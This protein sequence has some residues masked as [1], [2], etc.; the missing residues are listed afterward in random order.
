MLKKIILLLV[1]VLAAGYGMFSMLNRAVEVVVDIKTFTPVDFV[2]AA[3]HLGATNILVS[4]KPYF[5][6]NTPAYYGSQQVYGCMNLGNYKYNQYC[7]VI[8]LASRE[9]TAMYFDFNQNYN[10]ADDG[11]PLPN[12]G[13]FSGN[14]FGF[15]T[16]LSFPWQQV[17]ANS[18]FE[19]DFD[20]WFFANED[21]GALTEF[22]HYSRTQLEGYVPVGRKLYHAYIVDNGIND[23]DLT[24]DGISIEV[25]KDTWL[26]LSSEEIGKTVIINGKKCLFKIFY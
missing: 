24:N 22:S 3:T 17:M 19:G 8:D 11:V 5:I 7:F 21:R 18:S 16:T 26:E 12:E 14:R 23:A 25:K 2:R 1:V 13:I 20:I 6:K 10:L 4:E 9:N 15:A